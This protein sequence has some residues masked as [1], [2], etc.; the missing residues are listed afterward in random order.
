[1]SFDVVNLF[2]SVPIPDLKNILKDYLL[3]TSSSRNEISEYLEII[4][5]CLDQNYF[6][7]NNTFYKQETG[8]P[9]GSPLSPLMAEISMSHFETQ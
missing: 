1:V 7:F 4:E 5:I 3:H 6:L 8:L 9:M 2:L